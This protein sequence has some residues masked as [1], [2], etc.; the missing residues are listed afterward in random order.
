MGLDKYRIEAINTAAKIHDIGKINVPASILVKPGKI[1]DI[2]FSLI[3]THSQVGYDM[4]KNIE[5]PWPLADIILQHHERLDGSGY[6]NGLKGKDIMLEAKV[7]AVADVVEAMSS[8]R[9][10]RPMLG[11]DIAIK[12][13]TE[14]RGLLYDPKAVDAC[15]KVLFEKKFKF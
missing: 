5:F 4:I 9:P 3:K 8:H 2:E 14:N 1:T 11:L 10:Y 13:I 12:E 7:L 15:R 6:P